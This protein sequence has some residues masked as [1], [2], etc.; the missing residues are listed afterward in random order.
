MPAILGLGE[1]LYYGEL[2][3]KIA[4]EIDQR[5]AEAHTLFNLGLVLG[6]R[7][8]YAR[9]L[10]MAQEGLSIAEQIEHRQWLTYGH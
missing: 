3:L 10:E 2:A 7:G 1:S 6:P 9:T 4:R 8:E 5:E